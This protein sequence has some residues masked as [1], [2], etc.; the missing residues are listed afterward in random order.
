[1]IN[2]QLQNAHWEAG[3]GFGFTF[4]FSRGRIRGILPQPRMVRID[5]IFYSDH[6]FAHSAGTLTESGGSDH[7]PVFAGFSWV[8]YSSLDSRD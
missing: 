2:Q 8:K 7:L 1:M 5:H 6:F 4:P 3:W